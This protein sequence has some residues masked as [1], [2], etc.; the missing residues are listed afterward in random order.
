MIWITEALTNALEA[1]PKAF[2]SLPHHPVAGRQHFSDGQWFVGTN[3]FTAPGQIRYDNDLITG[4]TYIWINTDSDLLAEGGCASMRP[5]GEAPKVRSASSPRS[6]VL[7]ASTAPSGT[8]MPASSRSDS[9]VCANRPSGQAAARANA[10][11]ASRWLP[12][13]SEPPCRVCR[14]QVR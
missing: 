1:V 3:S 14:W 13:Q 11:T 8:M 7:S 6:I 9:R 4:R 5:S 12:N 10:A 2:F